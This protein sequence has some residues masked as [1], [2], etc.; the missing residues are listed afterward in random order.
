MPTN[1]T[2]HGWNVPRVLMESTG[3][4]KIAALKNPDNCKIYTMITTMIIIHG[5]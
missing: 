4:Q 2:V 5:L 3:M 1:A